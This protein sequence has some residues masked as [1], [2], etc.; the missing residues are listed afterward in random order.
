M[1]RSTLFTLGGIALAS[2]AVARA[3]RSDVSFAGK[4]VIVTGG[5]RGLGLTI[6][7]RLA[8][9]GARLALFARDEDE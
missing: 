5:S 1:K 4:V 8:A 6:A 3:L 9:E 2:W 7:R